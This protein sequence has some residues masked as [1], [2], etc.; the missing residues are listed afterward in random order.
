MASLLSQ[1]IKEAGS[2]DDHGTRTPE[3]IILLVMQE[4]VPDFSIAA[5]FHT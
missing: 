1:N 2:T 5:A 4:E 3:G